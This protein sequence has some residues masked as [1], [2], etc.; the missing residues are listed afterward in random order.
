MCVETR[1]PLGREWR[2]TALRAQCYRR[3]LN[4]RDYATVQVVLR[5]GPAEELV[6]EFGEWL[7]VAGAAGSPRYCWWQVKASR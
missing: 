4:R 5:F 2:H 6:G 1:G 7:G 3:S